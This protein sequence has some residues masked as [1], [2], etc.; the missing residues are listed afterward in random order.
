[1]MRQLRCSD[2]MFI[3]GGE[4]LTHEGFAHIVRMVRSHG[5]KR[6]LVTNG[7]GLTLAKTAEMKKAGL[8]GFTFYV[9]SH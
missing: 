5:Y 6:V 2:G 8:F 7:V 1:M 4:L 3:A 9:D